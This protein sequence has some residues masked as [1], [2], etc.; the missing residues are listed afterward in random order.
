MHNGG[1]AEFHK[2]KR[3]LQTYLSD[4]IFDMVTGNTGM[5]PPCSSTCVLSIFNQ[6]RN[7]L[8][9]CS[10]PRSVPSVII[11]LGT[12]DLTLEP[13]LPDPYADSYSPEV[14]RQAML[15][16]IAHITLMTEEAGITEVR[17]AYANGTT[18]SLF[19]Q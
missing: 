1:I 9:R 5:R 16:T 15:D 4:D 13:Q 19:P 14:L 7:G 18:E 3:R 8:S 11:W 2:I 12:R 10:C 6:T 17:M